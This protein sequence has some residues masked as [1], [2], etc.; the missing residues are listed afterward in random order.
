MTHEEALAEVARLRDEVQSYEKGLEISFA[1][2]S[3]A[4]KRWQAATGRQMDFPDT[5]DL[6][7]W[8]MEQNDKLQDEVDHMHNMEGMHRSMNSTVVN[9]HAR[10]IRQRNEVNSACARLD[11]EN[12][13]L[14][15][16][17]ERLQQETASRA[18]E[19]FRL[20][21]ESRVT[22]SML[23]QSE[24]ATNPGQAVRLFALCNKHC[25]DLFEQKYGKMRTDGSCATITDVP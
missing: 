7:V 8:L 5:T 24:D 6:C 4:T 19:I 2:Y 21:D 15:S 23:G 10:A 20:E 1:A 16:E 17:N 18:D 13:T 14:K 25:L 9:L 3:R 12:R 22:L 11:R